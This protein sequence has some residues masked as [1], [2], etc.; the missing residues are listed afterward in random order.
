M[1]PGYIYVLTHPSNP[2]LYKIGV[3]ILEPTKRLAQH[4]SDFTKAAGRVVK[5]TGQKWELKEFHSVPDPYWA[6]KAFWR[7]VPQSDIPYR[8]GVEVEIMSWEEVS[9]GLAAAKSAGVRPDVSAT[10]IYESAYDISVRRHLVGRG[11]SLLGQVKSIVSGR[12]DFQCSNGHQW[13]TRPKL[14]MGGEGCPECGIGERTPQE[15]RQLTNAGV[16][17]LLI[18]PSQPGFIGVGAWHGS[19]EELGKNYPWGDWE[20]ERYRNVEEV[21]IAEKVIWEL[22][23]NPLPHDRKS[24]EM[25]LDKAKEVFRSLIYVLRERLVK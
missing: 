21:D 13:R 5:E 19:I 2:D 17:G 20:L 7:K 1:K 12:N 8:G 3:T 15:M 24:I 9:T 10:P 6:E 23:G 4:N 25:D 18:N 11:I 14:V 16:I 22:L